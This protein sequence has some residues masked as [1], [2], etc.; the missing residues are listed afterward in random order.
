M[1]QQQKSIEHFLPIKDD[2]VEDLRRSIGVK[3]EE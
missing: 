1:Q 3:K 2:A